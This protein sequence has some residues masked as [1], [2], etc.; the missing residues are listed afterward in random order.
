MMIAE[1]AAA[2]AHWDR[3]ERW[4]AAMGGRDSLRYRALYT[5]AYNFAGPDRMSDY[6]DL[7]MQAD[8]DHEAHKRARLR[9][10]V[11]RRRAELAA[12]AALQRAGEIQPGALRAGLP[13]QAG[14]LADAVME[15]AGEPRAQEPRTIRSV[16]VKVVETRTVASET[17]LLSAERQVYA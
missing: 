5:E 13:G 6:L 1:Q 7:A 8:E 10:A 15:I 11:A 16:T 2:R 4:V 17:L 3:R 9:A 14:K 12:S